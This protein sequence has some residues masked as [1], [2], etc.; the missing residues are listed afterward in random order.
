[1]KETPLILVDSMQAV[2]PLME[3]F[4]A[5]LEDQAEAEAGCQAA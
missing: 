2:R 1:V 4:V 5:Q 3:K